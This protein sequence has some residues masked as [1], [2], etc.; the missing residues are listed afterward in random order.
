MKQIPLSRGLFALVDDSDYEEL[1]KHKWH[2]TR[3]VNCFY[4]RRNVYTKRKPKGILMHRAIMG[5][6]TGVSYDH[7]DGNGLN[8]QRNNL[9]VASYVQNSQNRAKKVNCISKYKGVTWHVP[10][11]KWVARVGGD[12]KR[13]CVGYFYDEVEAAKAYDKKARE[14]F[15]E[16]ARL[17]FPE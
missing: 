16:F 9:R 7:I 10:N 17:N 1:A 5:D 11:Q 6:I 4:A 15:G 12:K 2:T 8:N 14:L 3:Q 13:Y